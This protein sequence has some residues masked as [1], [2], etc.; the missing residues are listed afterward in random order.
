MLSEKE[1]KDLT[2]LTVFMAEAIGKSLSQFRETVLKKEYPE[3]EPWLT[4][5]NFRL[6]LIH[7][8]ISEIKDKEVETE[9]PTMTFRQLLE[10]GVNAVT[11]ALGCDPVEIK[12]LDENAVDEMKARFEADVKTKH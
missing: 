7:A 1:K 6:A 9:N 4:D 3:L 10:T 11:T 12:K 8:F 2:E 5:R